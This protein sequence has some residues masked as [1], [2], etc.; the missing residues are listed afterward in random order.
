M[1]TIVGSITSTEK[2]EVARRPLEAGKCALLVVDVQE[3]LLP[4]IYENDRLVRNTQL[5][6]RLAKLLNLPVIA[7]T[8]YAKGLGNIVPEVSKLLTDVAVTDKQ[9]FSCFGS[10]EFRCHALH[11]VFRHY[12]FAAAIAF[13]AD[14]HRDVEEYRLHLVTKVV[15]HLDPAAPLVR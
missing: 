14:L 1:G 9:Q 10:A 2:S 7:T 15:C 4:P 11:D 8:Q 3:K 13:H 6:I 5:L 12:P